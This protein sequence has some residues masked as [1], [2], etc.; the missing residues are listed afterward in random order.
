M[1]VYNLQMN[2]SKTSGS[3]RQVVLGHAEQQNAEVLQ[4]ELLF[5]LILA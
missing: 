3:I 5:V 4:P 2:K 1:L